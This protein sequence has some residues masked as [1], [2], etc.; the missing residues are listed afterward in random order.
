VTDGH[1]I[2][3]LSID[4]VFGEGLMSSPDTRTPLAYTVRSCAPSFSTP[5]RSQWSPDYHAHVLSHSADPSDS[6]RESHGRWP[7]TAPGQ[8]LSVAVQMKLGVVN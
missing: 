2:L 7:A 3:N 8:R 5:F 6:R 1:D 4:S